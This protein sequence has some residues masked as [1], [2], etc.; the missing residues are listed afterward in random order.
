[1][2]WIIKWYKK[3]KSKKKRETYNL[4]SNFKLRSNFPLINNATANEI[5]PFVP[6]KTSVMKNSILVAFYYIEE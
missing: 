1:M 4:K 2:Q 5:A 6:P 3:E